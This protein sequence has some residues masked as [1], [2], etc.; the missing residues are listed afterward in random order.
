MSVATSTY[1]F[2]TSAVGPA[3]PPALVSYSSPAK[4]LVQWL[5]VMDVRLCFERVHLNSLQSYDAM[6]QVAARWSS[7]LW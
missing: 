4:Q 7:V 3:C 6:L 1:H 5:P 2:A